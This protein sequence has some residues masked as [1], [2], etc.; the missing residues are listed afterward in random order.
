M[1]FEYRLILRPLIEMVK[2][3]QSVCA[4]YRAGK[5]VHNDKLFLYSRQTRRSDNH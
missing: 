2:F 5:G 3:Q 4:T 1:I